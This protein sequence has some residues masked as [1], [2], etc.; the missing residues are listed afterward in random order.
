MIEEWK[1]IDD[2]PNYQVS[3]MG[4]VKSLNYNHT[5]KEKIL[6]QCKNSKGYLNVTLVNKDGKKNYLVHRLVATAFIL[7]SKP[8]FKK[9]IDHINTDRTDNRVE[10]LRW[11]TALEN[12]NNPITLEKQRLRFVA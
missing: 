10:N 11:V 8:K 12:S 9:Q 3:N 6:K 7:N 1:T 2:Y 4:N 5:G